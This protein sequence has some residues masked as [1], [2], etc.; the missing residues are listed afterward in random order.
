MGSEA[1]LNAYVPIDDEHMLQWECYIP[2][3]DAPVRTGENRATWLPNTN[4]PYGRFNIDQTRE[5]DYR[6]DREAQRSP[7]AQ[8]ARPLDILGRPKR[9]L[10]QAE[11]H[12]QR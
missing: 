8:A 7:R 10:S 2:M 11:P 3:G 1:K 12:E 9:Q 6:I 4:Q 5:N